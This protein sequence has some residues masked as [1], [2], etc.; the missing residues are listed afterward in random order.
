MQIQG[1]AFLGQGHH[2]FGALPILMLGVLCQQSLLQ[3]LY[4]VHIA[5][6]VKV[7]TLFH[8]LEWSPALGVDH[9][10]VLEGFLHIVG[11]LELAA[12]LFGVLPGNFHYLVH[13]FIALGVC[14]GN[15][16]AKTGE[17]ADSALRYG[18]GLAVAGGIC[19]GHSQLLA[20]QVLDAAQF[21][22]NMETVRQYLS[23]VIYIA[24][25]VY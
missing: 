2:F 15:I 20:L 4:A 6:A 23:G 3:S 18:E 16:H 7:G 21:V 9:V 11:D 10:G 12:C 14:E 24:L 5:L 19:P 22:D 8:S 17:E 25:E 13:Y 1:L